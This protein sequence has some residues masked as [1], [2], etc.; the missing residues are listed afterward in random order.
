MI[1]PLGFPHLALSQ[2][3]RGQQALGRLFEMYHLFPE[4]RLDMLHQ[5][6]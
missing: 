4:Q 5:C 3:E 6:L 1:E 2:W